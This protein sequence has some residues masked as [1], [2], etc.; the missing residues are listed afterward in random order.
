M[1][2][3]SQEW[4]EA[5]E[6]LDRLDRGVDNF[7][8]KYRVW[9]GKGQWSEYVASPTQMSTSPSSGAPCYHKRGSDDR[10]LAR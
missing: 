4:R 1:T 10:V 9:G 2:T 6:V 7:V 5:R 3:I 8:A